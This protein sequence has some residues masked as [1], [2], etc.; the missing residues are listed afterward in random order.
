MADIIGWAAGLA[1][2]GLVIWA[3]LATAG[4][5][6]RAASRRK[7]GFQ[8][9]AAM[10]FGFGAVLDPPQRHVAEAKDEAPKGSPETGEPELD[11]EP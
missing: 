2:I 11:D 3:T 4:G 1:L 10:L 6:G 8:M 7:G 5:R 9:V